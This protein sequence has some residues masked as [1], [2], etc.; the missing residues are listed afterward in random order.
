M[1]SPLPQTGS[2]PG[3][4]P[5]PHPHVPSRQTP[6][7]AVPTAMPPFCSQARQRDTGHTRNLD[8]VTCRDPESTDKLK[9]PFI[10]LVND[11]K[12]T[13]KRPHGA[14]TM[15]VCTH[16]VAASPFHSPGEVSFGMQSRE[17]AGEGFGTRRCRSA[18]ARPP[19][20]GAAGKGSARQAPT[21][22]IAAGK[23]FRLRS[24][25]HSS[26]CFTSRV[27]ALPGGSV[28]S[29]TLGA[30]SSGLLSWDPATKTLVLHQRASAFGYLLYDRCL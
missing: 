24:T 10:F 5:L 18:G 3:A 26:K 12:I 25:K 9:S 1:L 23:T 16:R 19:R 8:L 21:P 29:F 15:G 2:V 20:R 30:C 13:S 11:E 7:S 4:V 22:G 28:S 27:R 17:A 14:A 6:G